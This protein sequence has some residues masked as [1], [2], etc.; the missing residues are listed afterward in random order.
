M[1]ALAPLGEDG[2][3]H[4]FARLIF[5]VPLEENDDPVPVRW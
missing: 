5:G 4:E 1:G 3:L 2:C